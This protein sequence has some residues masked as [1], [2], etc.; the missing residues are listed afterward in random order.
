MNQVYRDAMRAV[1]P[2]VLPLLIG[3]TALL[4]VLLIPNLWWWLKIPLLLIEVALLL[5]LVGAVYAEA[6]QLQAERAGQ[7][8]FTP[9]EALDASALGDLDVPGPVQDRQ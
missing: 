4:L 6:Q 1:F 7:S 9:L 3:S 2:R 5:G 8:S